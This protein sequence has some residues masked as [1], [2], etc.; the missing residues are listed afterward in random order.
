MSSIV[1]VNPAEFMQDI[2]IKE[3]MRT[4]P[5]DNAGREIAFRQMLLEEIFLRDMFSNENS[6]Y[7]PEKEDSDF[8]LKSLSEMY[9]TYVKKEIAAYLVEQGFLQEGIQE[10][11]NG[12]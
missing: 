10:S 3:G 4:E 9:G 12:Q 1:P 8:A 11:T 2:I 6:I 5:T 7:K